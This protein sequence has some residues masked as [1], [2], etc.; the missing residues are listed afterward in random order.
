[1]RNTVSVHDLRA[2]KLQVGGVNLSAQNLVDGRSTRQNDRLSFNLNGSLA[3]SHQVG[4]DTNRSARDQCQREDVSVCS[5]RATGNQTRPFQTLHSEPV[6][7]TDNGRDHVTLLAVLDNSFCDDGAALA[8]LFK[9]GQIFRGQVQIRETFFWP[10]GVDPVDLVVRNKLLSHAH[11]GTRVG[12][13]VDSRDSRTSGQLGAL[14][15]ENVLLWT[16]RANLERD[17]VGNHHKLSSSWVFW[18]LGGHLKTNHTDGVCSRFS[19]DLSQVSGLV[20]DNLEA[21]GL[22]SLWLQ[23]LLGWVG[24]GDGPEMHGS[25]SAQGLED[26][27]AV[28]VAL[29]NV[30]FRL[31]DVAAD[32][33]DD[34]S[35]RERH[36]CLWVRAHD[37]DLCAGDSESPESS[38]E[39]FKEAAERVSH[40]LGRD[41]EDGREIDEDVVKVG[42]G[43]VNDLKSIQN[44]A[45]KSVGLGSQPSVDCTKTL[46]TLIGS[47]PAPTSAS[48]KPLL[49]MS[50]TSSKWP[51]G[52]RIPVRRGCESSLLIMNVKSDTETALFIDVDLEFL[53]ESGTELYAAVDSAGS[54]NRQDTTGELFDDERW[55][56]TSFTEY[57]L[58]CFAAVVSP[59]LVST[60][61]VLKIC[62]N[63][64]DLSLM[65]GSEQRMRTSLALSVALA[66]ARLSSSTIFFKGPLKIR[67]ASGFS[68]KTGLSVSVAFITTWLSKPA[69]MLVNTFSSLWYLCT[70]R[71]P[72]T[73]GSPRSGR[74]PSNGRACFTLDGSSRDKMAKMSPAARVDPGCF[75]SCT[76]PFS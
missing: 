9:L 55:C 68:C 61:D 15:E 65:D 67:S 54:W 44:V 36:A 57:A 75:N 39:P 16:K 43:G 66:V 10:R 40:V 1:M 18:C 72:I 48:S 26:P 33:V 58:L 64:S 50:S 51:A 74:V 8:G 14:V 56:L 30:H 73:I 71:V 70:G 37:S 52:T 28:G 45:H 53:M 29:L 20:S 12:R 27:L 63:W 25:R 22:L 47:C 38:A 69:R 24:G 76:I 42:V 5:G 41:V 19:F 21:V 11:S 60:T 62:S 4:A 31:D 6:L 23:P 7:H 46:H 17:V 2:S 49:S 34:G 35:E 3:K 13:E 32:V 59:Y